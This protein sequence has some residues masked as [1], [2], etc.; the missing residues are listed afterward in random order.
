MVPGYNKDHRPDLKQIVFG[1][2]TTEDG[3]VPIVHQLFDG[4]RTDDTTHIDNWERLRGFPQ[5]E[6]NHH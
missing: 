2:N 6:S 3:H 4:N 1:M 5:K